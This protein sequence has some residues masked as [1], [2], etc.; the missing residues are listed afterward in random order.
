MTNVI[1]KDDIKLTISC[2][3]VKCDIESLFI[4]FCYRGTTYIVGGIYRHPNGNVSHFM[5]DLEAVLNQIDYGK[6]TVLTGDMNIDI[7]KFSNE[8]V[9]SYVTT[10][11][12]Y[13][14]LPYTTLPSRITDFSMLRIFQQSF[15]EKIK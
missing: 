11:I 7:T 8:D 15:P 4:A 9:V 6:T 5:S 10:L 1:V 12:P 3:C 13:G 2:D 14:N